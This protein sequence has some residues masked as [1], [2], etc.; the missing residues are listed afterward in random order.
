MLLCTIL[1]RSDRDRGAPVFADYI[2]HHRATSMPALNMGIA[3][4]YL[5][6]RI[7]PIKERCQVTLYNQF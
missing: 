1:P 3:C 4:T 7:Y 5:F 6:K 2:Q